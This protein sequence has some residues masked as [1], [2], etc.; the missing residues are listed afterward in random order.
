[1][2]KTQDFDLTTHIRDV[3]TG[4]I[5]RTQPYRVFVSKL[6]GEIFERPVGSGL[7]WFR[8]GSRAPTIAEVKDANAKAASLTP[9]PLTTADIATI[10]E[11]FRGEYAASVEKEIRAK[12]QAEFDS[13]LN[14][15]VA[16]RVSLIM[17]KMNISGEQAAQIKAQAS[18]KVGVN[19]PAAKPLAKA[20][21]NN[22]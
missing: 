14:D 19:E 20:G 13:R 21:G 16:D 11:D 7:C 6:H 8:D 15:L 9:K 22:K 4:V 18:A 12:A 3:R 1:M 5:T 17:S 10:K 2:S